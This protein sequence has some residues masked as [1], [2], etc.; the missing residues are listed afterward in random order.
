M[1][2]RFIVGPKGATIHF[3]CEGEILH[4][5]ELPPGNYSTAQFEKARGGVHGVR[6]DYGKL[7]V[8]RPLMNSKRLT[9]G[10]R[11]FQ[12][13]ANPN[14]RISAGQRQVRDL[15]R[16]M[17]ATQFAAKRAQKAL[18]AMKRAKS[19]VGQIEYA[20]EAPTDAGEVPA[21]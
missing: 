13:A 19:A 20:P 4:S 11:A 9:F 14:W 3:H 21:T 17:Q 5:L 15:Q 2:G 12:S 6:V 8:Q 7:F 18:Q 10:E 1:R 16:M